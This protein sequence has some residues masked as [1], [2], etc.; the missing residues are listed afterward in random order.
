M[1]H[2]FLD[3]FFPE[4]RIPEDEAQAGWFPSIISW[5]E[6]IYGWSVNVLSGLL[7]FFV[8]GALSFSDYSSNLLSIL[9]EITYKDNFYLPPVRFT[10]LQIT[11]ASVPIST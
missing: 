10:V 2:T 11:V 1:F 3:I 5:W 4:S 6:G 8:L 9:S 7:V